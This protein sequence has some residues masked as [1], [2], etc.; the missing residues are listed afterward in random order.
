MYDSWEPRIVSN[1][2]VTFVFDDSSVSDYAAACKA[3]LADYVPSLQ[4]GLVD[5]VEAYLAEMNTKLESAG[6][7]TV[8]DE[9]FRQY[10]E[11]VATR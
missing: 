3:I 5:D 6:I 2:T 11:W 1:P 7:G 4:L 10:E 9:L 8:E